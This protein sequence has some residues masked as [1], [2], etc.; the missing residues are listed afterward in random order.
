MAATHVKKFFGEGS[1]C[2][3]MP[4]PRVTIQEIKEFKDSDPKGYEEISKACEN[5]YSKS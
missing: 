2:D 4:Y 1:Q 5:Y 3:G